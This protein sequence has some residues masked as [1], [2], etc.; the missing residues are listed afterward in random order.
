MQ[1]N[2]TAMIHN[3]FIT[4]GYVS[5]EYFCDRKAESQQ[6]IQDIL[7]H[8]NTVLISPRRMGKTG[9]IEYCFDQMEI[10]DNFNT[11][12][13]DIYSTLNL[14]DFVFMLGNKICKTLKS[15]DKKLL[16]MFI[17]VV[18]SI[19]FTVGFDESGA[20]NG[21]FGLGDIKDTQKSLEEIFQY[22]EESKRPCVIAIDEFQQIAKYPEKNV[23]ALLRTYVQHCKNATFIFAG[24]QRHILQNMFTSSSKPFYHSSNILSLNAIPKDKYVDFASEMFARFGKSCSKEIVANLYDL[25]EGHTWYL[26]MVLYLAF[27]MTEKECS[28]KI[29]EEALQK[30]VMDN[31]DVYESILYGLSEKQQ[32]V[33]KAIAFEEKASQIQSAGFVS[34]HHLTSPSSVQ[35]AVEKLLEKDLITIEKRSYRVDDRFFAIW[36]RQTMAQ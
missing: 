16:E 11:I 10:K 21:S 5:P 32:M 19:Q 30:R 35:S 27:Y 2:F 33:L 6:L 17:K 14:N 8:S 1:P 23:E 9:L 18:K 24:S 12:F 31:E 36:L 28:Q 15:K 25:L 29:I 34:K 13:I 26:Q 4:T 20:I 22:L 7:G 3:P